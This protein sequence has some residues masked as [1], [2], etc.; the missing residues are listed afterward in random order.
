MKLQ[1]LR[2]LTSA[3]ETI[4]SVGVCRYTMLPKTLVTAAPDGAQD[5]GINAAKVGRRLARSRPPPRSLPLSLRGNNHRALLCRHCPCL[6]PLTKATLLFLP[7]Y[8]RSLYS[9]TPASCYWA[10]QPTDCNGSAFINTL[11]FYLCSFLLSTLPKASIHFIARVRETGKVIDDTRLLSG[12]AP[13][14]LRLGKKFLIPSWEEVGVL[15]H[16]ITR[17]Q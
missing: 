5:A 15:V 14:E 11:R 13:F 2:Q 3:A 17:L 7:C 10:C 6:H 12:G 8:E 16:W 4:N 1:T 9:D